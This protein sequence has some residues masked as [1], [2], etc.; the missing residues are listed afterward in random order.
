MT[1]QTTNTDKETASLCNL[2][3][4]FLEGSDSS[5]EKVF[6]VADYAAGLA[7]SIEDPRSNAGTTPK[8]KEEYRQ[9]VCRIVA[10]IQQL[11]ESSQE[12]Q[13]IANEKNRCPT[14]GRDVRSPE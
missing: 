12:L 13:T 14:L 8:T 6:A 1:T 11:Q 2:L 10:F 9:A 4:A 3:L 7:K 5:L